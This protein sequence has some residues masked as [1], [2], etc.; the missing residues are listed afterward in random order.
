MR[1]C[2]KEILI[3]TESH[4]GVRHKT[5]KMF[6]FVGR[7]KH[8]PTKKLRGGVIVYKNAYSEINLKVLC[9]TLPDMVVIEITD[10]SHIIVA[11]Y[12]P[13]SNSPYYND[14]SF[15]SLELIISTFSKYRSILV[16]GDLNTRIANRFP[17]HCYHYKRN[18]DQTCNMNGYKLLDTLSR[19]RLFVLNGMFDG[20]KY[21]DSKFTCIKSKGSSQVDLVLSNST[22]YVKALTIHE[23]LHVSDHC[24]ITTNI[25]IKVS[26]TLDLVNGCACGINSYVEFDLSRRIKQPINIKK[27]NL[28]TLQNDFIDLGDYMSAKYSNIIPSQISIDEYVN[29]L[30][31]G[32]YSCCKDNYKQ[33]AQ[34]NLK[35]TQKNCTS[36][37]FKAIADAHKHRYESIIDNPNLADYHKQEWL[38]YQTVTWQKEEE[39]IYVKK[40]E[41]WIECSKDPKKYWKLLDYKGEVKSSSSSCPPKIVKSYFENTIFNTNKIKGNPVLKD[42]ADEVANYHHINETT[43]SEL[44]EVELEAA[45]KKFGT[46]ISFDGLPGKVLHLIPNNVRKIILHLFT[47]IFHNFYPSTWRSQILS[48]IEK[49]GHSLLSPKLRG[50]AVG[51]LLSRLYDIMVD[52]R[53]GL[54]YTPNANQAGSRKKQ[55]C[56]IQI[57]AL[58][59][60]LDMA[61]CLGKTVFEKH[62]G[63]WYWIHIFKKS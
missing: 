60:V 29:E 34:N 5:P 16:T 54:W 50:I 47:M 1:I 55:G 2:D 17:T 28:L 30:T 46:G 13:P 61:K 45:I 43:D 51:P 19:Y 3:I 20:T 31:N 58:F 38:F 10:T 40:N 27:L 42:I 57:F 52:F 18:P 6:T 36:K 48:P 49:K 56:P 8:I 32:L 9:D 44:T 4:F 33:Y 39:E 7:S 59:L 35:P 25:S 12:I 11:A 14:S 26:P 21:F 53:F 24:A 23:K 41:K 15:Y 22:D 62:D 37:N 63:R